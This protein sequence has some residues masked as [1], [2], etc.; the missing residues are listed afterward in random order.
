M[1]ESAR[2]MC[3]QFLLLRQRLESNPFA[4]SS[5][6]HVPSIIVQGVHFT[7]LDNVD[8]LAPSRV[9]NP[10]SSLPTYI[11]ILGK[12][13]RITASA[14]SRAGSEGTLRGRG[15]CCGTGLLGAR[16]IPGV[17][18]ASS[19]VVQ[20]P[21][22]IVSSCNPPEGSVD[23]TRSMATSCKSCTAPT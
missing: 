11:Y 18:I 2:R 21:S 3:T 6:S 19:S 1:I 8:G 17:S 5:L 20:F 7:H 9:P 4:L 16:V 14:A 22:D 10:G 23:S 12:L 15:P 13:V